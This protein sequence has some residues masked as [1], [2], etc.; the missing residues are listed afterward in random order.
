MWGRM[1]G[2]GVVCGSVR[3]HERLWGR[4]YQCVD[5]CETVGSYVGVCVVVYEVV[6]SY[7]G[8]CSRMWGRMDGCV[9]HLWLSEF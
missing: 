4:M 5:V 8:V 1:W 9:V 3:S 7:V 2:Y 6:G